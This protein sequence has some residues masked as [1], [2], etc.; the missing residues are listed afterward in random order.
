MRKILTALLLLLGTTVAADAACTIT[1][2]SSA[3]LTTAVP[4]GALSTSTSNSVPATLSITFTSSIGASSGCSIA[5]RITGTLRAPSGS[6]MSYGISSAPGGSPVISFTTTVASS[7]S[8]TQTTT[9]LPV[10]LIIPPGNYAVGTYTD[11]SALV[12]AFDAGTTLLATRS[13]GPTLQYTQTVCTI[14]GSANAGTQTLDFSGS[15]AISTT[16]QLVT[17]GTVNCNNTAVMTLSS[18]QG[19]AVSSASGSASHQRFFDYIAT[20]TVN[21]GTVT[22]D[23]SSNAGTGSIETATGNIS[24]VSTTNAALSI[25]VTPIGPSKPLVAGSYSDVLTLTIS[26]D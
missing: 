10:Y 26:P 5:F 9:S 1:G 17:F 21:G 8:V 20:T 6:T 18:A 3:S 25:S 12:Q 11:A 24:A 23:T 4:T 13:V 14:G 15:T 22:L 16:A 19:A 2:I 7:A